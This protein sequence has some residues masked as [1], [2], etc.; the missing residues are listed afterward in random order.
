MPRKIDLLSSAKVKHA[1]PGLRHD[2]GGL[3]LQVMAGRDGGTINESWLFRFK[4]NEGKM[5]GAGP[6]PRDRSW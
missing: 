2:G 5:D 1:K 4:L 3:Y 6:D